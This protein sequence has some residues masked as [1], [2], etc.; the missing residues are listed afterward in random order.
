M[1]SQ[2]SGANPAITSYDASVVKIYNATNCK[3]GLR[4]RMNF[5]CFQNALHTTL[6]VISVVN[7]E[8]NATTF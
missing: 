3:A 8:P 2:N 7:P 1:A 4:I 6:A 5:P